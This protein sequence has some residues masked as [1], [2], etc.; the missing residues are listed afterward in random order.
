MSESYPSPVSDRVV[1]CSTVPGPAKPSADADRRTK[2]D[3]PVSTDAR[4]PGNRR[5]KTH[6]PEAWEAVKD[7]IARLYL[8]ENRRLKVRFF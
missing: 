3:A 4:Q 2:S 6:T 1:V 5:R 8:E 7:D